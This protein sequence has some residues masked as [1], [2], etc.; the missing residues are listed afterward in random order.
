MKTENITISSADK[1]SLVSNFSTMLTA[2]ISILEVV[3]SLL[4]DAKGNMKKLLTVVR[5]DLIQ[6]KHLHNSFAKFPNI[7]DKVMVNILKAAE[8]AG[9]LDQ[10]L[11][12]IRANIKKQ[13]EFKDKVKGA[14]MYP[15]IIFFVF[16]GV[17]LM[18]LLVVIPKIGGVFT[19]LG[20]ELPLPTRIM[21]YVSNLL[22]HQ[23]LQCIAVVGAVGG[24]F[25]YLYKTQTK[26]M[27]NIFFSFP[28]VSNLVK[29]IDLTQFT[30]SLAL[31]LGAGI[32]INGALDLAHD[33]VLKK[34]V[35]DAIKHCK[36]V[37]LSGKKMSD[38]M[39]DA[40]GIFPGIMIKIVEAGEK[41]GTLEHSL[42]E[43]SEYMDYQVTKGLAT[44]MTLLEPLLM[45]FVGAMVGGMMMS[46]ISPIYGLIGKVGGK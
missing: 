39:R 2:G 43:I 32:P 23:T 42:M 13:E 20:I 19:Q 25:Y 35:S 29:L 16:I 26:R 17:M 8:E 7:F 33:I 41:S 1:I 24:V 45:V 21:I 15:I 37:V 12:E 31:L 18:I 30:R 6:G 14:L 36:E 10:S 22:I 4:E 28:M 3:E 44:A 27:Q 46:I 34:D 40:K 5:D 9:T 38:G 11:K